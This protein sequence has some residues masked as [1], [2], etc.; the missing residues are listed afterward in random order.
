LLRIDPSNLKSY[1]GFTSSSEVRNTINITMKKLL[2][3]LL[4]LHSSLCVAQQQNDPEARLRELKIEL[5]TPAKPIAN[6]VKVVRTGNLLY[7]A[8]HGP[9]KTDGTNITGK[10]GKDLTIEQGIEA[11]RVTAISLISTLKAELGDLKKVKRIV[12]V[13]AWVN[14]HSDFADQPKV[15]NGCSDLLV[16]VFGEKGRHA[17]A[18]VG[19]NAL[20]ANIAV[21][22]E[23]IVEVE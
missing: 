17:R 4:L 2:F 22:I 23:M 15:V 20:P 8:G 6:Y 16:V 12:K 1:I 3:Y 11:A 7:L 18:A 19:T 21:E 14:C 13:N 5:I 10:V 9:T